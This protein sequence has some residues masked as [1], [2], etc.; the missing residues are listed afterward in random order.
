MEESRTTEVIEVREDRFI[1]CENLDRFEIEL[2]EPTSGVINGKPLVCGGDTDFDE[3]HNGCYIYDENGWRY[4]TN[5]NVV[6][7]EM[8]SISLNGYVWFTGGHY[9]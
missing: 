1:T 5:L 3:Y 9:R 8:A 7:M 4:L 2:R 6:K